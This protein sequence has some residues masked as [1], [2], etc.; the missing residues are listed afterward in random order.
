MSDVHKSVEER[1]R[2]KN[3][4]LEAWAKT[5]E[6]TDDELS[7]NLVFRITPQRCRQDGIQSKETLW[8]ILQRYADLDVR[9]GPQ[10]AVDL[11]YLSG[12]EDGLNGSLCVLDQP[13]T[14]YERMVYRLG[15]RDGTACRKLYDDE[16][17]L[18]QT[19][20]LLDSGD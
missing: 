8:E 14:E 17:S 5:R 2:Y 10:A 19:I 16:A 3:S 1:I 18:A 13:Y 4:Q 12:V 20:I 6:L 9:T 15:Y 11:K 7:S